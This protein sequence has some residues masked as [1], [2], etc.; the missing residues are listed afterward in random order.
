[1][2]D[3]YAFIL[4][5]LLKRNTELH[6]KALKK[7]GQKVTWPDKTRKVVIKELRCLNPSGSLRGFSG[8]LWRQIRQQNITTRCIYQ[9][10]LQWAFLLTEKGLLHFYTDDYEKLIHELNDTINAGAEG[11]V[12]DISADEIVGEWEYMKNYLMELH[13]L[14]EN[15]DV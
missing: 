7:K 3:K 8:Y 5:D 12:E 10:L 15:Y 4:A 11:V 6:G 14:V 13:G 2:T 1:M 9:L